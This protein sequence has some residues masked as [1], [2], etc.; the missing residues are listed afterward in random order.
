MAK[1]KI[2][3]SPKARIKLVE[4][5]EY[6]IDRNKSTTYSSKLYSQFNKEL[7]LLLKQPDLGIKTDFE[8]IRGLIVGDY[9]LF[10]E[11]ATDLIIVHTL[12]LQTK[13]GRHSYQIE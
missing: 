1:R 13:S 7:K 10:Y 8:S 9:I 4:I 3:W 11:I 12:G 5:L 2:I 6:F